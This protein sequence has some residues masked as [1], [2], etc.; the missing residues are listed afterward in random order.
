M[1][2]DKSESVFLYKASQILDLQKEGLN[3]QPLGGFWEQPYVDWES[4]FNALRK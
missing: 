1:V 3:E 4:V 2:L